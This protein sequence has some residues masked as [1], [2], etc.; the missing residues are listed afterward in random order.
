VYLLFKG[1]EF[2]PSFRRDVKCSWIIS[3]ILGTNAVFLDKKICQHI[4]RDAGELRT[5]LISRRNAYGL[6]LSFFSF[7]LSC[8]RCSAAVRNERVLDVPPG[9]HL[10]AVAFLAVDLLFDFLAGSSSSESSSET[11]DRREEPDREEKDLDDFRD[12]VSKSE[13]ESSAKSASSSEA[14]ERDLRPAEIV[15][16]TE[17]MK[18]AKKRTS[19][20]RRLLEMSEAFGERAGRGLCC[21]AVFVI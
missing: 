2:L 18:F 15:E 9:A 7:F 6:S 20:C 16:S 19:F 3:G 5:S 8:S 11:A 10:S 14:I 4:H 13:S 21:F 17:D 12:F 1:C